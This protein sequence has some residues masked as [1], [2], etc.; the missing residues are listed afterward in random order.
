MTSG[1]SPESLRSPAVRGRPVRLFDLGGVLPGQPAVAVRG[2]RRLEEEVVAEGET[3]RQLVVI[4]ARVDPER[5]G[6]LAVHRHAAARLRDVA[7]QQVVRRVLLVDED[8]VLDLATRPPAWFGIG[9]PIVAM[10]ELAV[11]V[12]A[13]AV[14]EAVVGVDARGVR[15]QLP[16]RS[17][18]R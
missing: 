9:L 17:A 1:S 10:S 11:V 16:L 2:H 4:R 12:V 7:E 13:H 15:V 6:R 14:G 3:Q 5:E 18:W 8:D